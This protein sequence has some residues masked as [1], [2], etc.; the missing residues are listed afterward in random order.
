MSQAPA[1]FG[2]FPKVRR[3]KGV[4]LLPKHRLGAPDVFEKLS[5]VSGRELSIESPHQLDSL[6][7]GDMSVANLLSG[8]IGRA[9]DAKL[10]ERRI[11]VEVVDLVVEAAVFGVGP[12]RALRTWLESHMFHRVVIAFLRHPFEVISEI[13]HINTCLF[14]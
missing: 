5:K 10:D 11:V 2:G 1:A 4:H 13:P 12:G 14:K 6:L 3:S 9:A 7:T 8:V